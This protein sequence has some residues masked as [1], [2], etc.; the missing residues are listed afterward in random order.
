MSGTP[1]EPDLPAPL[2]LPWREIIVGALGVLAFV[3]AMALFLHFVGL[4]R[5]QEIIEASGPVAPLAYIALKTVTF[6]FA[7]LTSGPIQLSSGVLFGL[8]PGVFFTLV[9]EVLG[10]SINFWIA[11]LFGRPVVRRFVGPEGM[12]QVD[13][14]YQERL[15]GW[16]SLAVSRLTLFPFYDFI[17]YAAGLTPLRFSSYLLVSTFLGFLPTFVFVW[18]GTTMATHPEL[19]VVAYGVVVI[20]VILPFLLRRQLGR[21]L[22]WSRGLEKPRDASSE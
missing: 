9:G 4:E 14:F 5:L 20:A 6:V 8:W 3:T 11:R 7:P 21:L 16:Q 1:T 10:G 13:K 18:M 22:S 17:S 15:G 2:R 19:I 12:E